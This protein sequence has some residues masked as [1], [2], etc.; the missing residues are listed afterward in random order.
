[1]RG[2]TLIELLVV[3]AIIAILAAILF[4]VFA[5]AREKARRTVCL[6]NMKQ[7]G[8]AL[9]MYTQDYDETLPLAGNDTKDFGAPGAPANFLAAL[10]PY[11]KNGQIYACPTA[12]PYSIQNGLSAAQYDPTPYSNANFMGNGVVFGRSLAVVPNPAD[13]VYF[14]E[15]AARGKWAWVR[16]KLSGSLY[17]TWHTSCTI[18]CPDGQGYDSLHQDGGNLLWADGHAKY[19]KGASLR[20]F[21]F[22]LAEADGTPSQDDWTARANKGYKSLF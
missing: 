4:P 20:A 22:G 18:G 8:L 6:S 10:I 3:I 13:T 16:P 21:E 9:A 14:Q 11:V 7:D 2:F 17:Y 12:Q 1:M 15:T 5:Q 19:R